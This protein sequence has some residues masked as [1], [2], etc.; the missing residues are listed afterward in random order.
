MS[1]EIR[2]ELIAD[3]NGVVKA[4]QKVVP[5][6]KKA[7]KQAAKQ[8]KEPMLKASTA[9][10]GAFVGLGAAI[11]VA[12]GAKKFIE[13][14][15]QQDSAVQKLNASLRNMGQ[16]SEETS[17][18]LQSF[19][20]DLQGRS[21]IGDEVILD[22]LAFAQAMGA[23]VDQSKDI[24]SAATDMS[25][26]LGIDLN[27]AV[28]NIS[29][30]LG[31]YAGE[32][33]EVIPELKGLTK[34]QLQNGEGVA[35]LASKYKGFAQSE[36]KTFNGAMTQLQNTLGDAAEKLGESVVKSPVV[37]KALNLI[38]KTISDVFGK[39]PVEDL[40]KDINGF[41]IS[42]ANTAD[43]LGFLIQPIVV[44]GRTFSTIFSAVK[45]GFAVLINNMMQSLNFFV[46]NLPD[47]AKKFLPVDEIQMAADATMET[48]NGFVDETG[49]K[50]EALLEN[51][52]TFSDSIRNRVTEFAS[53]LEQSQHATAE[54]LNVIGDKA[55]KSKKKIENVFKSLL[56]TEKDFT[57]QSKVAL[58]QGAAGAFSG[59]FNAMGAAVAKGTDV[60]QA[61][62]NTL[63]SGFGQTLAQMGAGYVMQG[64][65]MFFS[66]GQQA[67]A[68]ALMAKGA[69]LGAFGGFLSAKFGG[70]AA[71]APG[72]TGAGA[73]AA[74]TDPLTGASPVTVVDTE[75]TAEVERQQTVS[76]TV[77]GDILDSDETGTR[78]LKI[79]N[80]E[81]DQQGARIS[82]A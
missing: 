56:K 64:A 78:L 53:A 73:N 5:A 55:E 75:E 36:V 11:G 10:K 47:F 31:G 61:G 70:G 59:A 58:L 46:S 7:G 25:S 29:K 18:S 77:N 43:S 65:A 39:F 52:T 44:I 51:D 45:L 48:V 68:T 33:G 20:S 12:M 40:I 82:Y 4:V 63:L 13:A 67:A 71:S 66:P 2:I 72:A 38:S 17:Q 37:I 57:N 1:E 41:I 80:D 27:S 69:A 19:A 34:E 3:A 49:T 32:L 15:A 8:I 76:L 35:L 23:S 16:F 74:A 81:F 62:F 14:A 79:L 30:T 22:Q 6:S 28:R 9:I 21:I 26:A 50:F 24:L 54:N 60:M 42:L